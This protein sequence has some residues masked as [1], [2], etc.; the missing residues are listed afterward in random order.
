MGGLVDTFL[1]VKSARW[2]VFYQFVWLGF[3]PCILYV[4]PFMRYCVHLSSSMIDNYIARMM[5]LRDE[6]AISWTQLA[7]DHRTLEREL[8][9]LWIRVNCLT[10][11]PAAPY[12]AMA[13]LHFFSDE[14][15]DRGSIVAS[16]LLIFGSLVV[17][18]RLS[19]IAS[20]H[21]QC[22]SAAAFKG[23]EKSGHHAK[24]SIRAVVRSYIN[25]FPDRNAK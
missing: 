23:K 6:G 9:D 14:K 11:V 12:Y 15:F 13:A 19:S 18:N 10:L 21:T 25:E 8:C 16:C 5:R 7:E 22:N 17:L 2:I 24:M 20:L 3:A 1:F 4:M